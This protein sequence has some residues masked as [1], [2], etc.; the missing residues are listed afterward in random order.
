[1]YRV[2][3]SFHRFAKAKFLVNKYLSEKLKSLYV[4]QYDDRYTRHGRR[5]AWRGVLSLGQHFYRLH[6]SASLLRRVSR[7]CRVALNLSSSISIELPYG[8]LLRHL[9]CICATSH[10]IRTFNVARTLFSCVAPRCITMPNFV[11][12]GTTA[13]FRF[14]S[15]WRPSAI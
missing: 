11:T 9:P 12:I 4:A 2:T 5:G 7:H 14:F 1:M 10:S 6:H 8:L 13:I 15:I 3:A